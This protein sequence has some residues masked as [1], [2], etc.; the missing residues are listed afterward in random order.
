[1]AEASRFVESLKSPYQWIGAGLIILVIVIIPI[2]GANDHE[3]PHSSH[4][5][6]MAWTIDRLL[7]VYATDHNGSFPEGKSSTEIFQKL[8]DEKYCADPGVFYIEMPGKTKATSNKLKPKNVC[9]DVTIST[10]TDY[11]DMPVVFLTGYKVD[12]VPGGS[13]IPLSKQREDR[14][15]GIAVGSGGTATCSLKTTVYPTGL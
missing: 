1:M 15:Q 11:Y 12:Y 4:S 14:F 6:E 5:I 3:R 13:A 7:L 2:M 9:W 10:D 8:L